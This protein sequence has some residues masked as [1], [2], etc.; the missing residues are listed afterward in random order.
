[1]S[2]KLNINVEIKLLCKSFTSSISDIWAFVPWEAETKRMEGKAYNRECVVDNHKGQ[3]VR[4]IWI[5]ATTFCLWYCEKYWGGQWIKSKALSLVHQKGIEENMGQSN[6][7]IYSSLPNTANDFI[8]SPLSDSDD[9][10]EELFSST[11]DQIDEDLFLTPR[12]DY[13][14][15]SLC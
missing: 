7:T 9:D 15:S 12:S 14:I 6:S 3:W 2:D 4:P 10:E 13:D 11:N 5:R 8:L 1:M